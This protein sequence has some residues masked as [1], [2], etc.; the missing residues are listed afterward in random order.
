MTF[1]GY[2]N[3]ITVLKAGGWF[4]FDPGPGIVSRERLY[5][6]EGK[7]V[8]RVKSTAMGE[9]LARHGYKPTIKKAGQPILWGIVKDTKD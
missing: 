1:C 9:I 8:R 5:D 2:S 6:A 4:S 7:F 3:T